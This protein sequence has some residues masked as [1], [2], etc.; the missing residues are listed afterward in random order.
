SG[1]YSKPSLSAHPSHLVVS[2]GNVSLSC[3]SQNIT[4]TFHLLKEREAYPSQ[5]RKSEFSVG[6]HQ[7]TFPVGPVSTS[8]GGIYRCYGS[9]RNYPYVWSQPSDSVDLTVTGAYSKPFLSAHPSPLVVSGGSV[10]LSCSS[11]DRMDTF[12]LLKEGRADPPQ[13]RKSQ[14]SA[15][16]HQAIFPMG[17]VSTYDG[18]T[19]RCYGSV[20]SSSHL[21]SHPSD[22]LDLRVTGTYEK[23]SLSAHP[24]PSVTSGDSVTLQCRS[25]QFFDTFHLFKE[26]LIAPPQQL[27]WQNNTGPFQTNFTMSPVTSAHGGTYRCY[28]SHRISPYL[29]SQP[30]DP[31][32][33]VVS[34]GSENQRHTPRDSDP[35][36]DLT[37]AQGLPEYLKVLIGDLVAHI[38][39]LI[40]LLL[41]LFNRCHHDGKG[42]AAV[43]DKQPEEEMEMDSQQSPEEENPQA[44]VYAQVNH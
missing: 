34:G 12:Y 28:S 23:P 9:L 17:P 37:H 21:W 11:Q 1:A 26:G 42:N 43:K 38:S 3:S 22:P 32:E 2:G 27:S 18:G 20:R 35:P 19:Y 13:H 14:F 7:A 33:L 4:D 30:S 25:D 16:R 44:R 10:S 40:F 39:L 15:G 6:R 5:Q 8:H 29:F 41:F 36:R 24:G 31:L